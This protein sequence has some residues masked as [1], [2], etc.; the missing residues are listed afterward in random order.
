MTPQPSFDRR[1]AEWL[2]EAGNPRV[3]DYFDGL[4]ERTRSTRQRPA[5]ASLERWLPVDLALTRR[6]DF[7]PRL[8]PIALLVA[9]ILVALLAFIVGGFHRRPA[10][11]GLAA[12]GL[13]S[14]DAGGDLFVSNPDGTGR[15]S[16]TTGPAFDFGPTFSLDGTRIAYWSTAGCAASTTPDKA[17]CAGPSSLIVISPDGTNPVVVA[18]VDDLGD[19]TVSWAP[20]SSR[21]AFSSKDAGPSRIVVADVRG[22]SSKVITDAS[23]AGYDPQWSP[24]GDQIAFLALT[25]T[26]GHDV[27]L[28]GIDGTGFREIDIPDGGREIGGVGWAPDGR[29][30]AFYSSAGGPH[31]IWVIRLDGAG[32]PEQLTSGPDDEFYPVWSNAGTRLA[33]E[34]IDRDT[35]AGT[36]QIND[37]WVMN[38]NGTGKT[39][40]ATHNVTGAPVTWSPDD[41]TLLAYDADLT[42]VDMIAVDGSAPQRA[43]P[44]QGNYGNGSF[45]RLAP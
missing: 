12:T 31:D 45:Q 36:P 15:R 18:T 9:L 43:I 14:F 42:A 34:Q 19:P 10:P 26:G 16:L 27:D 41:R 23:L 29:A 8:I 17:S 37:V 39:K 32:T 33:Y 38:A 4:L 2:E 5:W 35:D 22:G 1:L 25:T 40:L 30:L 44:A 6:I 3:P 21:L 13:V 28:I 20:D 7:A 11:Y 24:G